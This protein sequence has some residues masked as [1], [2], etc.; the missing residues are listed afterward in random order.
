VT[1][2]EKLPVTPEMIR[3][4]EMVLASRGELPIKE[5]LEEIYRAMVAK[6]PR[7]SDG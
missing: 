1:H 5:L 3:A 6:S 4:G 7:P 2:P